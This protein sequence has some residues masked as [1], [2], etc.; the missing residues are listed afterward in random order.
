VSRVVAAA[1]IVAAAARAA[2][3]DPVTVPDQPAE[4][5][6]DATWSTDPVP[7]VVDGPAL[8]LRHP[9]GDVVAVTVAPAPNAD[10]WRD[11]TR[12]SYQKAVIAGFRRQPGVKV[13]ASKA[14]TVG[15]V[16]CVDVTIRRKVAGAT[17]HV[18]VR[19]LLFRTRTIAAAAEGASQ[20]RVEAAAKALTPRL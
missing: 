2:A 19:L 10:A 15:G 17:Q 5:R 3:A 12:S 1:L 4:V 8:V 20:K 13:V 7:A 9:R 14:H 16:P 18:A 6:L 11:K